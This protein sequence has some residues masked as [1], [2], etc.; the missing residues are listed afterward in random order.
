MSEWHE[1]SDLGFLCLIMGVGEIGFSKFRSKTAFSK[2]GYFRHF[3]KN[4]PGVFANRSHLPIFR[5]LKAP[6]PLEC[7]NEVLFSQKLCFTI[8]N[9]HN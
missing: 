4:F 7:G 8:K 1:N 9:V 6:A 3:F 2:Q 5:V